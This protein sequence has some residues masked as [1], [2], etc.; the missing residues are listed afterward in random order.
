MHPSQVRCNRVVTFVTDSQLA[1]LERIARRNG[2]SLS[3]ACF[4]I[5]QANIPKSASPKAKIK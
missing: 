1:E 2:T 4:H 5:L 3:K